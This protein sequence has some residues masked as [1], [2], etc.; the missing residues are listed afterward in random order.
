MSPLEAALAAE[1]RRVRETQH[2]LAA[3]AG[4]VEAALLRA[5]QGEGEGIVRARLEEK[6]IVILCSQVSAEAR[7]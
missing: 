4:H 7:R 5:R 2:R 1:L 6:G 3:R